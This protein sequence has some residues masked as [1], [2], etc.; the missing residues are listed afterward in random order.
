VSDQPTADTKGCALEARCQSTTSNAADGTIR[1]AEEKRFQGTTSCV[2]PCWVDGTP[3][4]VIAQIAGPLEAI[5]A[6][7][8]EPAGG[9]PPPDDVASR[10]AA[11]MTQVHYLLPCGRCRSAE[12][13]VARL[14]RLGKHERRVLL[15]APPPEAGRQVIPPP[16]PGRSADEAHRRAI[17]RLWEAG[18][19]HRGWRDER[20][21]TAAVA[22]GGS[23]RWR[24]VH[25]E[26]AKRA[27]SLSPLGEAVVTRLRAELEAG[28]PIRWARHRDALVAACRRPPTDLLLDFLAEVKRSGEWS[29]ESARLAALGGIQS[30][31]AADRAAAQACSWV[32]AAGEVIL[33]P[34]HE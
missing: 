6:R 5:L 3:C 1:C 31:A 7:R 26:Y 20:V 27:V 28:R 25:R 17:G 23:G 13:N 29:R 8:P 10:F 34:D 24:H 14:P 15:A 9:G 2:H 4:E 33:P 11:T 19:L 12:R 18:L 21:K 30:L 32:G 22:F 16:R